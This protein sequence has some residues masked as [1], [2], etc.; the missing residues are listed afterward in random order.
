M[1]TIKILCVSLLMLASTN[2]K[3][4]TKK[5]LIN[6][7]VQLKLQ[8][9]DYNSVLDSLDKVVEEFNMF[10]NHIQTN[11]IKSDKDTSIQSIQTS[12][13]SIMLATTTSSEY[14]GGIDSLKILSDSINTIQGFVGE[15][16]DENILLKEIIRGGMKLKDY[17]QSAK[18][19]LGLWNFPNTQVGLHKDSVAN[20]LVSYSRMDIPDAFLIGMVSQVIFSD[21]ELADIYFR[22]GTSEKCFYKI[23]NFSKVKPYT[24]SFD[25][26]NSNRL[27]L[28][29]M[30]LPD[31]LQFSYKGV[32]IDDKEIF[33]LGYM[34]K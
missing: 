30:A 19:F 21:D 29:V 11:Y 13:D 1:K 4:Q 24:I 18:D 10:L 26:R 12:L 16:V 3:S 27:V 5:D 31:G 9:G 2:L 28:I 22:D 25:R 15:V 23:N 8:I 14:V 20:G 17:P 6:Q 32:G 33:H 34:T 7:N